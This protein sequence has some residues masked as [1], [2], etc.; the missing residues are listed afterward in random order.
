VVRFL[1]AGFQWSLTGLDDG[2][3]ELMARRVPT[4]KV[5]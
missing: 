5:I 2:F 1:F 4:P 3:G